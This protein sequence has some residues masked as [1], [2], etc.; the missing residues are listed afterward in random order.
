MSVVVRDSPNAPRP[1]DP[2]VREVAGILTRIEINYGREG[3]GPG[4]RFAGQLLQDAQAER[5]V[6]VVRAELERP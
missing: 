2:L 6:R 1:T 4:S 5:V 3:S